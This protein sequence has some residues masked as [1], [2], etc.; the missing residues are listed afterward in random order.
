M[1]ER[2]IA[3]V[4]I[5]SGSVGSALARLGGKDAPKLFAETRIEIPFGTTRSS[6]DLLRQVDLALQEALLHAGTVAA[7]MRAHEAV[8]EQ[9]AIAS[10]A[11][12]ASPP[13][14]AM[15]LSG[16][17]ADFAPAFKEGIA[18]SVESVFGPRSPLI[19]I[20][21]APPPRTDRCFCFLRSAAISS[22]W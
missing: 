7:R 2:T 9:G 21:S 19:F 4:D 12:F 22:V 15:H 18:R 8:A 13:W 20:P 16:G 10:V 3:L 5:E 17:T 1:K 14:A 6:A 11:V